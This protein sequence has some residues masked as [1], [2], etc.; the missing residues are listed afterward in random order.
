MTERPNCWQK[1]SCSHRET[2][3]A[4]PD[5]GRECF[6]VPGTVCRGE[7]QGS[8]K[9]KISQCRNTCTFYQDMMFGDS[10]KKTLWSNTQANR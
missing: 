6:S 5:F 1:L 9:D 4:Y 10:E 8:Y 3:P 7:T 2:C